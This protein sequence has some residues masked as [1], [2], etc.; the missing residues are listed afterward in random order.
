MIR[1]EVLYIF[2]IAEG[3]Y[4]VVEMYTSMV[5]GVYKVV[6]MYTSMVGRE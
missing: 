4:R 2:E 6:E 1:V 3:V 5:G